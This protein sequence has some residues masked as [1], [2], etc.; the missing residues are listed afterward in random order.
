MKNIINFKKLCRGIVTQT[1]RVGLI[2]PPVIRNVF[3]SRRPG[4]KSEMRTDTGMNSLCVRFQA[5]ARQLGQWDG[6]HGTE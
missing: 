6:A 3:P 1:G 4:G 2:R 5:W